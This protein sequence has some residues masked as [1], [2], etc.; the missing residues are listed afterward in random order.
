MLNIE[1]DVDE[2]ILNLSSYNLS[3]FQKLVLCRGLKFPIPQRVSAIDV[4]ASF[5]K[6][7]WSLEPHLNS[8]NLKELS[9][10]TFRSVAL[11]YIERKSPKSPKTL[12][13]AIEELKERDDIVITKPDKGSGVVVL[14]KTEYLR[15]LSEAS[16]NDTSKF[17]AVPLEKPKTRGRPPK[18]YHPLLQKEKILDS[19]VRRILP[20]TIADSVSPSGSRLAHLH[21]LPKTHKEQL[22]MK[23]IL[24]ATDTYNYPLAKWLDEKLKPLSLN[25]YAV[26]DIFDFTNEIHEFKIIKGEI[27]VSND[28]SSLFTNVPLDETIEILVNNWFNTTDNLALTR[29]DLFDLLSVATKGQLFQFDG[30]LYEQTDGVAM[31][32]PL[33]PLLANVFMSSI[34]DTLKRQGKFLSFY[35][36]YVDDT[37]T[38][39]PDLASATTFLHTLNSDHTSVK[40]TMEW[41]RTASFLSLAPNYSTMHLGLKETKVYVKH[42]NTGLL[43]HY[44]SH[45]DNRYKW[46]LLTTMLDRAHR[47]SSS[48]TFFSEECDRL[49][50]VFAHL[51]YPERLVNYTI[52]TFLQSRIVDKQASQTPKQPR[53]IVR[54]VIPFKDQESANYVKKELKNLSIKVQTTVQPVFVSHKIDQDLKVRETKPQ[55]VN[56]QRVVYRFQCDLCDAG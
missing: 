5:E 41:K 47:L 18:H 12:L 30:A 44:Q 27:F 50:K 53:A 45:V 10:A 43:L 8:D 32:S 39:I 20:K 34:E 26:T 51:K 22:A 19:I 23:P 4:K 17:C 38:V 3:F 35:R 2:H 46:S 40:F 49:K 14:D 9:A 7:Y 55:I 28:V 25:H 48:W 1:I 37:L 6:A 33:G 42:I 21:G 36:R 11:N 52:N 31:G 16:I 56:Q 13:R 24:S 54:V 15:L 29:T